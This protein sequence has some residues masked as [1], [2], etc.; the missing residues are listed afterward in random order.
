MK[1]YIVLVDD[2]VNLREVVRIALESEGYKVWAFGTARE[3]LQ[4]ARNTLNDLWLIDLQLPDINGLEIIRSIREQ[5]PYIPIIILTAYASLDTALEAV[6]MHINDYLTKP[7]ELDVLLDRVKRAL[8]D[9]KL[10]QENILLRQQ[11]R[12]LQMPAEIIIESAA[13]RQIMEQI[14]RIAPTS[15]TVIITG[16][17]GVG[18]EIMARL[19][20]EHSPRRNSPFI[21]INCAA[22]PHELLETEL[23]GHVKGAFTGA[24]AHKKGL[25]EAAHE[26]TLFLDEIG[27]MP[28]EMQAKLL[29]VLENCVIRP[30]GATHEVEVNV[31]LIAATNQNLSEKVQQGRF[32]E[33]LYYRLH[34]FHIPIPPLRERPEDI[35]PLARF[36]LNKHARALQRPIQGLPPE[37]ADILFRYPWPGN[38]RELENA[39]VRSVLM[40]NHE[41]LHPHALPPE[42]VRKAAGSPL[43]PWRILGEDLPKDF[44]LDQYIENIRKVFIERALFKTEGSRKKTAEFLGIPLRSLKYYMQKYGLSA[45]SF[46]KKTERASAS[47]RRGPEYG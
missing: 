38:V 36:F 26:G 34:V 24:I 10:W 11:L 32:R 31:R 1:S 19:I 18:K 3:A 4:H 46:R 5:D 14:E 45:R 41:W 2:E 13:M 23:F 29:R 43:Q 37:T 40:E 17:S 6:R 12:Q 8:E 44:N 9:Y 33:D 47:T 22:V 7:F 21:S 27:D 28:T 39:I 16:E 30:I 15:H 42:I 20:H 35:L 25:F